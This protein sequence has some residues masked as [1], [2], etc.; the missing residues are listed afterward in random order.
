MGLFN[1]SVSDMDRGIKLALSNFAGNTKLCGV[2]ILEGCWRDATQ[3]NV[4]RF[5]KWG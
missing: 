2:D 1:I 5:K 3:K 4:D